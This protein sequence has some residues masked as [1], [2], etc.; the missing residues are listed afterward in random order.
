MSERARVG[1]ESTF[2]H[3]TA[4]A[5]RDVRSRLNSFVRDASPEQVRAWDDSIPRLQQELG[6]VIASDASSGE[7]SAILE[8]ELPMELRRPDAVLLIRGP[9]LVVE[10]KGKLVP[11]QADIDQV[12]SYA[13]DLRGYHRHCSDRHVIPILVPVRARG[14]LGESQG[15]HVVGPD[16]VDSLVV[17]LTAS[18]AS[19]HLTRDLFLSEEA[20]RPLPTLV[21]A[22]RELFERG[23]IRPIWRA[24]ALTDPAL[25][26]IVDI[27]H[28]AARTKTRKLI[29]LTGVPGAGKT[30]VGLRLAHARF[31]DDLAVS[32]ADGKPTAPAVFLSGNGP[33]V[34]V[35]QYELRR[36]GGE[37]KTFVRGVKQ[38]VSRYSSRRNLIPP[39][40]VLVFDE[41]QRAFDAAKV[42]EKHAQTPGFGSGLSE[43]E[44]FIEFA[45]RIPDW[46]VVL[47]L[48]GAGQE[49]HTGEE[50]GLVQWRYAVERSTRRQEWTVLAPPGVADVFA[51][52]AVLL[53]IQPTLNLDKE[54][55]FH[56]AED[57]HEF[58]Q[59]LLDGIMPATNSQRATILEQAGYHLRLTRDLD[60]AKI[61]LRDRYEEA[62][63]ARF[64]LLASSKDKDLVAFG[65]PN[66]FQSTK[67][68][69]FGP[70]YTDSEDEPGG[71]S[72]RRL[73]TCVTE[74]GAQGLELDG[75]LLGWGT[76]LQIHDGRWSNDRARGYRRGDAIKD[77]YQLRINAYRVLL[78][79]ARDV[80]VIFVPPLPE[81]D[82]TF[83]YLDASGFRTFS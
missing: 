16:A 63:E 17:R 59:G 64:G 14:Y 42:R 47:G 25:K 66:D 36:S 22:A 15:V 61:Y 34:E 5:P 75:V 32:R 11:S 45:D 20:Y 27:T 44:H 48:I 7:F 6:E 83:A 81:L 78:T 1:W 50:A 74:F 38:Y 79:R 54:I 65:I 13:R 30:L 39:E 26:T 73:L 24:R 76:D 46:C 69:R 31:L 55:R 80:T 82:E 77:P 58:V 19:S 3:F 23:D 18:S 9:V 21:E 60:D 4:A 28:E 68:I 41:A 57:V 10:L 37:G 12:S 2:S 52:S 70:W 72:C 29:L 40:H 53:S 62:P 67:R 43:P 49:I 51:G 8:Y 71:W 56:L 33:L 35:L